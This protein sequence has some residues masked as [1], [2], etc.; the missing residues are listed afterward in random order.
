VCDTTRRELTLSYCRLHLFEQG[1]TET[2]AGLTMQDPADMRPGIAGMPISSAEIKLVS[3]PDVGDKAAQ[4]YLSTDRFDVE[5]NPVYGR[6]EVA[7]R[8]VNVSCGYYMEPEKTKEEFREDGWFFT[9]D[10]GQFM[11]D[12][13]LRIV[14]RKKNLV[15]LKG[16]EYVALERMEGVFG[17]SSF[18]DAI[19]GGICCCADGDM[20][21]PVALMLLNEAVSMSWAKANG[22]SGDFDTVKDSKELYTAVMA[23][24]HAQHK[25]SDLSHLEKIIAVSLLTEPWTPEN[26]CLTA[27]N[28]LQRRT[29]VQTFEKECE[30]V[31][32][33]GVFD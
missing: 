29:V 18:V 32:K 26:G 13:S 8:G 20:D 30:E 14:D 17:N 24:M 2:C 7:T 12:G 16:G 3:T 9:G 28:K 33:K 25:K 1:L 5:G 4:P 21:R 15:K 6:G 27:A 19:A 23:D 31:K 22:V 10:I 11:A